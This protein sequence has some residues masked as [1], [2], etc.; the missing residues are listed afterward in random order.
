MYKHL[1]N[2]SKIVNNCLVNEANKSKFRIR[3]TTFSD[4]FMFKLL[5]SEFDKSQQ[6]V[7]S[8]LN[9]F[10]K[11]IISR[12]SYMSRENQISL[13]CYQNI[14]LLIS[15]YADKK[16]INSNFKHQVYAVDGTKNNLLRHLKDEGFVTKDNYKSLSPLTL[17]VYNVLKNY[18][19]SMDMVNHSDERK[20]F[21]EFTQKN[22]IVEKN[23]FV[24]DRGYQSVEF[25]SQ[26]E[27]KNINFVCRIRNNSK[28]INHEYSENF[29]VDKKHKLMIRIIK[30]VINNTDYY[31]ATN[32]FDTI[33][34]PII[35]LKKLYHSRWSVEEFFKYLKKK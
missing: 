22:D 35:K 33:E 7:T 8:K 12:Q 24:F 21:L 17:C 32:L 29:Y 1:V 31:L 30:Y 9:K 5:H 4:G 15:Q 11:K 34:F 16:K 25:F 26:L 3:G 2:I 18:P 19:V 27:S 6:D 23:I 14:F 28:M 13:E 20:A 10:N